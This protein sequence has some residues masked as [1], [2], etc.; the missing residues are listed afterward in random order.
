MYYEEKIIDGKLYRRDTPDGP[1]E[2]ISY[3][4]LLGRLIEA[5]ARLGSKS[6]PCF[7]CGSLVD[8]CG[9][10]SNLSCGE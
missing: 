10:C 7:Y 3:E 6:E 8:E 2:L 1:W 5:E 9:L 4:V